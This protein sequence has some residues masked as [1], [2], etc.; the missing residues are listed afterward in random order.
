LAWVSDD[1]E[2]FSLLRSEDVAPSVDGDQFYDT[3]ND[4]W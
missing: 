3:R 4:A 1:E 2:Q